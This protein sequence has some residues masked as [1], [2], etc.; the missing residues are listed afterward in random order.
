MANAMRPLRILYVALDQTVPGTLGGSVH[1]QSVAEGLSALGHDVHVA[2]R[3]GGPWPTGGVHWTAMSPPLGRPELRW[4]RRRRVAA[5]ARD[6]RADLII[7][8]YYNFGG[9]GI[10]AA[11]DLDIPAVLEVNAPIIDFPGSA[12]R[13]LDRAL[14]V[15]PMRRWRDRLSRLTA[16]FVTPSADILP[17]WVDRRSVLEIEWGA[18][19]DL[20]RPDAPGDP[21]FAPDPDRAGGLQAQ[22]VRELTHAPPGERTPQTLG[23]TVGRLDDELLIVRTDLA[24]TATRPPRVQAGHP[25]LVEPV[26]HLPNRVLVRLHQAGDSRHGVTPGRGEHHH[27]PP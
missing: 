23:A 1:V 25:H 21:P 13:R 24:G 17:D 9:E 4:L 27:G 19:V 7:E 16:L 18:D 22:V 14:V 8:R 3:Q 6:M 20:F 26:D 12:K 5:L 2:V 10:L 11:H 15:E